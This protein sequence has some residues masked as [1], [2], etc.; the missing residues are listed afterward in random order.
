MRILHEVTFGDL[1]LDASRVNAA[2]GHQPLDALMQIRLPEL[3][4]R[5][6]HRHRTD[7]GSRRLPV[8]EVLA[9]PPYRPVPDRDDQT[10]LLE[11]RDELARQHHSALRV[12]PAQQRLGAA[13]L[14]AGEKALRLVEKREL[15]AFQSAPQV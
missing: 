3:A 14:A 6:V 13:R 4:R 12:L 2:R 15:P 7:P 11:N 5:E 10:G 1:E 8:L 9:R